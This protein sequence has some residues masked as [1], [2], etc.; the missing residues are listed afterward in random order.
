MSETTPRPFPAHRA[1]HFRHFRVVLRGIERPS[2]K[3]L[4]VSTPE[5]PSVITVRASREPRADEAK[6]TRCY[7]TRLLEV[8]AA[9]ASHSD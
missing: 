4:F 5:T 6:T 3:F 1:T 2:N 8:D 7:A 9:E